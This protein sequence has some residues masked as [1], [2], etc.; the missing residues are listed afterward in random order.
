[1]KLTRYREDPWRALEDLQK[2]INKL[3]DF[4]FGRFLASKEFFTPSVDVWEDKENVYVEA[5]LPGFEQKDIN[6]ALR[7]NLLTISA[8][9]EEKKEEKKKG[10]LR[11]E[12]FQG[13]FYRELELPKEVDASK[14]KATYKN[15]VLKMTLPKKEEEKE[16]EIKIEIE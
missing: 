14:I 1:M 9:R 7:G 3:F 8:E 12:R 4:S 5:D 2:E 11:C 15:G 13:K 16:K 6:L 10:Y